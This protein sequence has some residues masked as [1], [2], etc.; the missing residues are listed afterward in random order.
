MLSHSSISF[1]I[2]FF[3]QSTYSIPLPIINGAKMF[4][5]ER[6]TISDIRTERDNFITNIVYNHFGM[7]PLYSIRY[8]NHP[9]LPNIAQSL[10]KILFDVLTLYNDTLKLDERLLSCSGTVSATSDAIE[11]ST[12]QLEENTVA[13]DNESSTFHYYSS[14]YSLSSHEIWHCYLGLCFG[15]SAT[16]IMATCQTIFDNAK[17]NAASIFSD[18]SVGLE[19]ENNNFITFVNLYNEALNYLYNESFSTYETITEHILCQEILNEIQEV[20]EKIPE[21]QIVL[22]Q[23]ANSSSKEEMIVNAG[24][25]YRIMNDSLI[26]KY[27]KMNKTILISCGFF[28]DYTG[29]TNNGECANDDNSKDYDCDKVTRYFSKLDS[30]RRSYEL[31]ESGFIS[32]GRYITDMHTAMMTRIGPVLKTTILNYL[33]LIITKMEL[34]EVMESLLGRRSLQDIVAVG[35]DFVSTALESR[36][37]AELIRAILKEAYN[38]ILT[39]VVPI[40]KIS[41]FENARFIQFVMSQNQPE[42]NDMLDSLESNVTAVMDQMFEYIWGSYVDIVNEVR[43]DLSSSLDNLADAA[44]TLD[45]DLEE[46]IKLG[47]MNEYFYM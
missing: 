36:R 23:F 43:D 3:S 39:T 15:M 14:S 20:L 21:V 25:L 6:K 31:F 8:Q 18:L 29:F 35:T 30:M 27:A 24:E 9:V 1:L 32:L 7:D 40:Y 34:A 19:N 33:D 47:R 38:S 26:Q 28:M 10:G 44:E 42:T 13:M 45:E 46:Y 11:T 5:E 22:E 41:E 12:A 2:T 17:A 16:D 4:T 37:E